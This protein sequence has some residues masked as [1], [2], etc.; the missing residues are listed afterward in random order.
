M[1]RNRVKEPAIFRKIDLRH[2]I[3]IGITDDVKTRERL[4][5]PGLKPA[6]NRA[7]I[8]MERSITVSGG[9]VVWIASFMLEEE[10][11]H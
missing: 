7:G 2:C 5:S 1:T 6:T 11:L 4:N 10:S 9:E 8:P 3:G